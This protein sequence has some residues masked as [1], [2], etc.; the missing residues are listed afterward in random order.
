[1]SQVFGIRGSKR[2]H[3]IIPC[4]IE[5]KVSFFPFYLINLDLATLEIMCNV[6]VVFM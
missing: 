5:T 2:E 6:L 4:T 1:M 3:S